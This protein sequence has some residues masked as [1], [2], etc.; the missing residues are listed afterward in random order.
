MFGGD[1][2]GVEL[3]S[4]DGEFFVAD[5]HDFALCGGG[6][7]FEAVGGGFFFEEEGVVAGG[8]EVF[9]EVFEEA[10]CVVGNGGEF[11]VHDVVGP[12]DFASE[13][14]ADALVAEADA[15]DGEFAF[16]VVKYVEAAT[17]F[18]GGAGTWG[19]EDA[20]RV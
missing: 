9:G 5:A 2:F 3:D 10:F 11:A 12:D 18:I 4:V 8:L 15:H 14:L 17:G 7:D 6:G 16:A 1:G 20:V 19:E 13:V